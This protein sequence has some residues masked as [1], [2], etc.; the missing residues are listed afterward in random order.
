MF[1]QV[2]SEG[3][4]HILFDED[5]VHRTDGTEVKQQDAFITTRTGTR[6]RKETTKGWNMLVQWKDGSNTWVALKD[7]KNSYPLQLAEYAV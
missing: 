5:T 7:M 3:N 6:R 2:D 1:A 4:R